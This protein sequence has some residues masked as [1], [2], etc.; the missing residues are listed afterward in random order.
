MRSRD[1]GETWETLPLDAP[2]NSTMWRVTVQA[3]DPA[4]VFAASRFGYL[5]RSDDGGDSWHKLRR[6]FSEIADVAWFPN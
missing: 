4:L 6:E 5:Y 2:P 3:D 1:T